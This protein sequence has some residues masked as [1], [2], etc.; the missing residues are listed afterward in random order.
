MFSVS[1]FSFSKNKLN[2][3]TPSMCLDPNELVYAFSAFFSFLFFLFSATRIS[4]L[5]DKVT[6]HVL[7]IYCSQNPQLFYSE[8]KYIKNKSHDT[9]QPFKSYFVTVLSV[10]SF[11]QNKLYPNGPLIKLLT[12]NSVSFSFERLQITSFIIFFPFSYRLLVHEHY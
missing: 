5:R 7:F 9:I 10:F 1:V 3:N 2:P 12:F 8:K 11:Q 4:A 6:V